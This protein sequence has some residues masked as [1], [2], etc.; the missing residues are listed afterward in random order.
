VKRNLKRHKD[1][2]SCRA[3]GAS[4]SSQLAP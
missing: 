3:S 1:S 2:G 4:S